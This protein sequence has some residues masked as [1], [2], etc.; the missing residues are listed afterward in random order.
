MTALFALVPGWKYSYARVENDEDPDRKNPKQRR[1]RRRL[2]WLLLLVLLTIFHRPI[3]LN[4]G[5][6]VALHFAAKEN[7]RADFRLEGS[8]FTGL[9]IR[10][11]HV[12]PTGPSP[13]E[14][15]DADYIR[16][17]YS[18]IA[19][20]FHGFANAVEKVEARSLTFR[21]SRGNS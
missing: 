14:S 17:N 2:V 3:L 8:V 7:L 10:N 21:T 4:I 6:R 12:V 5:R 19:L 15:I 9:T 18:L 20:V 13:V 1:R 11:L 16:A